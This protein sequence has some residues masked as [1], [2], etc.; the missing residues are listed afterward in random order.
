MAQGLRSCGL[1]L[2]ADYLLGQA[3][4]IAAARTSR[5]LGAWNSAF[6]NP[7]QKDRHNVICQDQDLTPS[8]LI[9]TQVS[10]EIPGEKR[11]QRQPDVSP[12]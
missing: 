1:S 5:R 11:C 3:R 7:Q 12:V 2:E 10:N 9:A 6:R 8:R 4:T